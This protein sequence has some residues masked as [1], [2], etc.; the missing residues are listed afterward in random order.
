MIAAIMGPEFLPVIVLL[1]GLC[2]IL[3]LAVAL[4]AFWIWMLVSAVQNQG[5]TEGEKIAWVLVIV[6]LHCLGALLYF[7]V[8]HPKRRAPLIQHLGSKPPG[9]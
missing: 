1:L 5:L 9:P 8:G 4:F 2:I 7:L 6:L 3:P